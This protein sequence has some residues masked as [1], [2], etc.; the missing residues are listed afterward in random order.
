[1][2]HEDESVL[3]PA[4]VRVIR[5]ALTDIRALEALLA[6]SGLHWEVELWGMGSAQMRQR[7]HALE[8]ETG[9][10]TLP[11]IFIDGVF[12]GGEPELRAWLAAHKG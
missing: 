1:M 7:F 9:W 2:S 6:E 5:S 10:S 3:S 12:V 8:Q 4:H 11:Q